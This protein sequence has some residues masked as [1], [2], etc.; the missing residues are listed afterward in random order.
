MY[1]YEESF[2]NKENDFSLQVSSF[3]EK[4]SELKPIENSTPMSD[5]KLQTY[6][7][8]EKRTIESIKKL[9]MKNKK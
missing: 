2:I 3:T 9:L 6:K 4:P 1:H 7:E 5:T 8:D